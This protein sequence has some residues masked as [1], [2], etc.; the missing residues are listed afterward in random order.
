MTDD[1]L[2]SHLMSTP[3]GFIVARLTEARSGNAA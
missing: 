2:D 1:E 3:F